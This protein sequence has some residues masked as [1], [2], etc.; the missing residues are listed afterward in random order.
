MNR[1]E[2]Y[3]RVDAESST[4]IVARNH[5][6]QFGVLMIKET[7]KTE[8]EGAP[9]QQFFIHAPRLEWYAQIGQGADDVA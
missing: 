4:I 9:T 1:Q 3:Q 2:D 7:T 6:G 8:H 5:R